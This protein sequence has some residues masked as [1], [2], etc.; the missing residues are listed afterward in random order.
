MDRGRWTEI[1]GE[2]DEVGRLERELGLVPGR[3]TQIRSDHRFTLSDPVYGGDVSFNEELVTDL[4]SGKQWRVCI[5]EISSGVSAIL[6]QS[7]NDTE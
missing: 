3:Y 1:W 6:Y 4:E 7:S 5:S 2:T